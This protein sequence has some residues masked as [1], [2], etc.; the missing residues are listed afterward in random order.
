ML[1]TT[2]FYPAST[3]PDTPCRQG[4]ESALGSIMAPARV[5]RLDRG[6]ANSAKRVSETSPP[7]ICAL[8]VWDV[9]IPT[10]HRGGGL[11]TFPFSTQEGGC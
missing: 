9:T 2:P 3:T 5:G 1:V 8:L 7:G 6:Q 10:A 11:C 4:L